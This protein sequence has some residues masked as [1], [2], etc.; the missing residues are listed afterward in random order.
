MLEIR[1]VSFDHAILFNPQLQPA[2]DWDKNLALAFSNT[3][4]YVLSR[5]GFFRKKFIVLKT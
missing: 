1:H 2:V 4:A 3:L 5:D